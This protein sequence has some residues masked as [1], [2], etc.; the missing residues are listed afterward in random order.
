MSQFQ[1]DLQRGLRGATFDVPCAGTAVR[2]ADAA[3]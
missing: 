2:E 3:A 1:R